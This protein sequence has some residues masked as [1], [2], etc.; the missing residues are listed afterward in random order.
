MKNNDSKS[1][2]LFL[3]F[4]FITNLVYV[5]SQRIENLELP[6]ALVIFA[7]FI[8]FI[9]LVLKLNLRPIVITLATISALLDINSI[10]Y[11]ALPEFYTIGFTIGVLVF[12]GF[13]FKKSKDAILAAI[14][15]CIMN[16]LINIEFFIQWEWVYLLVLHSI[17][18]II[19]NRLK[20]T[21]TKRIY[22]GFFSVTFIFLVIGM[23]VDHNYL[24]TFGLLLYL[25]VLIAIYFV[26]RRQLEQQPTYKLH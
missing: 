18:F 12:L 5:A 20:F 23:L 15:F 21:I 11:L 19:A 4:A 17:L 26:I 14:G 8:L 3:L 22:L 16:I 25:A 10:F 2:L 6:L 9:V 7:L 13:S 24:A 1:I